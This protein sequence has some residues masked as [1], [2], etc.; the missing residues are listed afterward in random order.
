MRRLAIALALTALLQATAKG[1]Q[2]PSNLSAPSAP[3]ADVLIIHDSA[4]TPN[5]AGLVNGYNIIDLLGHFGLKGRLIPI[6]EYRPGDCNHF[7]YLI[8]LGVDYRKVTY[9][10]S[11]LNDIRST[12][13]PVL[14]VYRHLDELFA[15]PGFAAKM[16]F[17]PAPGPVLT[18]FKSV[19]YKGET[20][21]KNEGYLVPLNILDDSKVQ[22]IA[23]SLNR[24]GSSRPYIIRSGSFWYCADDPFSYNSEGDRYLA[25]CDLLHDFFGIPHQQER[26]ALVRIE[27]VSVDD[28]NDELRD[29]ADYLHER[30]IPFQ[31][32]LIPIFR[33]TTPNQEQQEI[34]LSDR[35]EF[36][37]T[38]R[39]MVSQ[40]G[41]VVMHGVYHQYHGKSADDYEFWDDRSNRPIQN[42]SSSLV[43]KRIRLGLEECFKNG[44]YPV[45]WETPH[46]VAS[47]VDYRAIAKIFS[48]S[49]DRVLAFNDPDTGHF[50][51]YT[52]VDRFGRFII[53]ESLGY[54]A[55]E[56]P[57]PDGLVEN[58]RRLRVVRDGVASFFFHPFM[59]RKY[60]QQTIDGIEQLG[61]HFIS[62]VDYDCKVQLDDHVVQTYTETVRLSLHNQ[63]LHKLLQR[64]DGGISSESYSAKPING[65]IRD[66]GVVPPD[67]ILVMEGVSEVAHEREASTPGIWENLWSKS[68]SWIKARFPQ[69]GTAASTLVQPRAVVLWEQSSKMPHSDWN[70][71]QS[72]F[73]ALSNSGFRV[74]T[75]NW[76]D[77]RKDSLDSSSVIIVPRWVVQNLSA[78]QVGWIRDFVGSGGRLV[79]DGPGPLGEALGIRSERRAIKVDQVLDL[80]YGY[81]DPYHQTGEYQWNPVADV[82][83]FRVEH[84]I[85]TYA[86]DKDSELPVA[87]LGKF[88]Q[89]LFL[90]LGARLD[91]I[92]QYGY[93]RYPYFVHYVQDGFNIRLPVQQPRL[94]LYFDPGISKSNID[95]AVAVWRKL[96]VRALYIAAYQFWPSWE[97]NYQHLIDICHKNGILAYAWFELPHVSVKFWKEHPEWQAKTATGDKAGDGVAGWRY[98]MDL[99]IPE[100]REAAFDFVEELIKKYPWD[101]VNIAE[102]NYDS[103]GPEEP[104]S[105]MP[106]GDSSRSAFR[107]LGGFD[108]M[109]LFDGKSPYFWK[110]NPKALGKFEEFRSQ[111]VL[112]WHKSLL[113]RLTPIAQERGMEII[114]TMLDSLH[115]TT[116]NRGAGVDSHMIVSLMD[117]FPFTLQ[118]EDPSQFWAESPDR[119]A[120]FGKTYLK[121]VRDPNRLMF[122]LNVV[123]VRDLSKSHSPTQTVAG[124]ELEQSLVFAS[125]ASGRAAIYSEGTIAFEDLQTLSRVLAYKAKVDR[126]WSTWITQS[127]Q[128]ILLNTPGRWQDFRV[129][130]KI[131][132]GWGET[133]VTLPAGTHRI[134]A[135]ERKYRFFDTTALDLRLVRITGNLESLVP[136]K[137]GLDFTYNSYPRTLALFNRRPFAIML[138]GQPM[139]EPVASSTGLW[140]VRLPRGRH[141]VEVLADS[142]ASVILDAASLYSSSLIVVFGGV[143]CGLMVLLYISILARRAL[144]RGVRNRN[145]PIH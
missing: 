126:R 129:D 76:Q 138:D 35:P 119:Y 110:R 43:E 5:P 87:V 8:V 90:Y 36:V 121:L 32:S 40:G 114:V 75:L 41:V 89:G 54:I 6:E 144:G 101:G 72:Y 3:P 79:L 2:T 124:I 108:P 7:K 63:Y 38:I 4:A 82:T 59:D 71:Q 86:Q 49:W 14:W 131:W 130:G 39:Y 83:R 109:L 31:I 91:P 118:V 18:D 70:N 64:S 100:C 117:Q 10:Q 94:E 11:L 92:S 53:P 128:S 107:A 142:T 62:I 80:H 104:K 78:R 99:D 69:E 105:Y 143:A 127:D 122:D 44:I 33:D 120:R 37:R 132:P 42:D 55:I 103:K 140:S 13:L 46:Y 34:Y 141:K 102:L 134:T 84:P 61:Y 116:L 85:F 112:A 111:R 23:T 25:F 137:R 68:L 136:T 45:S 98:H 135:F 21:L 67:Q 56:D 1:A 93:T 145:Q 106:M 123:P 133:Y 65:V 52:S 57:N 16:G 125:L 12:Q 60:L 47:E 81:N 73:N 58:A 30:H 24:S 22:V 66:P 88:G 15:Q 48:T 115:S 95:S 96:G 113:E 50:F 9:P 77:L 17:S 97:Y 29:L 26:K 139:D 28:D 19:V 20:L 27:D 74:E 51:P